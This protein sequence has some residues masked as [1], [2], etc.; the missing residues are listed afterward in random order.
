MCTPPQEHG[1]IEYLLS[2]VKEDISIW[3][4][5]ILPYW[6]IYYV[7]VPRPYKPPIITIK[8]FL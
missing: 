6:A 8:V 7:A 1:S 2:D 5:Q 3:T 4:P